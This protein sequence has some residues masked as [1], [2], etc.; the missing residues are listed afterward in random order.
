MVKCL[1]RYLHHRA[2]FSGLESA[3]FG[4]VNRNLSKYDA[5]KYDASSCKQF[6]VRLRRKRRQMSC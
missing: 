6:A 2:P 1:W 4:A 3:P 5:S